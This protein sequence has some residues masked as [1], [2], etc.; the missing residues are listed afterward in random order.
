MVDGHGLILERN[1][2][3]ARMLAHTEELSAGGLWAGV[4]ED[5]TLYDASSHPVQLA[6][7]TGM[8]VRDV[9]MGLSHPDGTAAG[10]RSTPNRSPTTAAMCT[11]WWPA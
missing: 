2:A 6:L 4:R 9:V 3:A 10:C 8:S 7:V 5:G 1:A 11:W